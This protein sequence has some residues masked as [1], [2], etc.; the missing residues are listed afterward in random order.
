MS[1]LID[2]HVLLWVIGDSQKLSTKVKDI[3]VKEIVYVSAASW[4]EMS[5]KYTLGK[6]KLG[7]KTPE[8]FMLASQ[9]MEFKELPLTETEASTFYK[10]ELLTKDPFDRILVITI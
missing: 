2:T 6:L 1:Y 3:L 9:S 7:N 8:D 10:L 5:I 4:W